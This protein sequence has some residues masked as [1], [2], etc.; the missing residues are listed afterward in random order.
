VISRQQ[1]IAFGLFVD[2]IRHRLESGRVHRYHR[3]AA[4]QTRALERDQAQY[5]AD[6]TPLR[7]SH[8]QIAYGRACVKSALS[9][10]R[11][12]ASSASAAA[13]AER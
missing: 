7:F 2:A 11:A 10:A 8:A 1:L 9:R 12:D 6:L 13:S 3:T 4:Q 5:A